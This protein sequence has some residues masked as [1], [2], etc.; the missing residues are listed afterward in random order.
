MSAS[1]VSNKQI[2]EAIQEGNQ[3]NAD[4]INALAA[5]IAGTQVSAPTADTPVVTTAD[6]EPQRDIPS[7]VKASPE[8]L[9]HM[10]GK[11]QDHANNK[12]EVVVLYGRINLAGEHKLAYCLKSRWTSLRDKGLI[13]AVAE[14]TPA[15]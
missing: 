9:A 14:F 10:K 15:S 7:T 3:A 13:G 4:A 5:A 2:I 8:Y 1:R 6:P 11:S 12:G